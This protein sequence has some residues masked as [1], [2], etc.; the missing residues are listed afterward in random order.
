M[1]DMRDFRS[2]IDSLPGSMTT[3]IKVENK[4]NNNP[5]KIARQTATTVEKTEMGYVPSEKIKSAKTYDRG[6]I[7][8][9]PATFNN[10]M[11]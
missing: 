10:Q 8:V 7:V 5:V 11:Y 4:E 2:Q 9:E 6:M 3:R 1:K